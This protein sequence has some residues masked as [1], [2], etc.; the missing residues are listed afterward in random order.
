LAEE[1]DMTMKG[2]GGAVCAGI[3]AMLAAIPAEAQTHALVLS[4]S[5][6]AATAQIPDVDDEELLV[7]SPASGRPVRSFLS[8]LAWRAV[9]GDANGNGKFD[10]EPA[11][12]DAIAFPAGF[13]G[14]PTI[15]DAYLSFGSTLHTSSGQEALD[16]D[17]V[18]LHP[19]GTLETIVS[20]ATLTAATGT[21]AVD[22]DAFAVDAAGTIYFSFAE[23]EPTTDLSLAARNGGA[24]LDDGC[25]FRLD[26]GALAATL[27]H[28][29]AEFATMVSNAVGHAVSSIV[30]VTEVELDPDHPGELL[31]VVASTASGLEGTVFTTAG[32]G[33][34]ATLDG[35]TLSGNGFGFTTEES[36]DGLAIVPD[37][38]PTVS[39][40]A[41][42]PQISISGT[43]TVTVRVLDGTPGG[44]VRVL[45][46]PM[47]SPFL[48]PQPTTGPGAGWSWLDTTS[49]LY[50]RSVSRARFVVTLD[51]SGSGAFTYPIGQTPAGISRVLQP[52]DEP[53]GTLGDPIV[54]ETIP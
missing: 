34:V 39:L 9:L 6:D 47:R 1:G 16:G 40:D 44:T 35:V 32:G 51:A 48:P 46:S 28:T 4:T 19:D 45:A 17:V 12:V 21:T 24:T 11:E 13:H 15:Y 22:V 20:E 8:D 31:F 25:V 30:D 41:D 53:S 26:P 14:R 43:T 5:G 7:F 38:G 36:L 18:R 50:L 49:A 29:E 52:L 2:L 33:A 10:D 27:V 37:F 54:L 3:G 42:A 23:N